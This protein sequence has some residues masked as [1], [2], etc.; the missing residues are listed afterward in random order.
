MEID[1]IIRYYHASMTERGGCGGPV[2]FA[3]V[4]ML[5][6]LCSCSAPKEFENESHAYSLMIERMD[7]LMH[8][9]TVWQQ[10]FSSKQTSIFESLKQREKNDSSHTVVVNE[11]GDTVKETIYIY[12]EVEKE[13]SIE[14]EEKE[15]WMHKFQQIDSML[16]VSLRKQAETDSLLKEKQTEVEVPA[17]LSWWPRLR[18]WLGNFTLMGIIGLCG[19]GGLRLYKKFF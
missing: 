15:M 2:L 12:R 11:K 10:D 3:M 4:L 7:S 17:E 9:T 6:M 1:N 19:Y 16:Q 5:F 18:L 13:S 8:S 14:K